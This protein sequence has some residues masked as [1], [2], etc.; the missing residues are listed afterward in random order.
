MGN[1][2]SFET[3]TGWKYF[4]NLMDCNDLHDGENYTPIICGEE[5]FGTGSNH[6]REKDGIWAALA[7]LQ[8]LASL[9]ID[10]NKPL[11]SVEDVVKRH[12]QKYGRYYYCRWD[13]EG[14]NE[15]NVNSMMDMMRVKTV[16]NKGLVC[17][18]YTIFLSDEFTY[19]DPVDGSVV[20]KQGIRFFT[21]DGSRIVFRLSGTAGS[22]ATLRMYIEQYERDNEKL[23]MTLSDALK[24]LVTVALDLCEIKKSC[25]TEIPTVVT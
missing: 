1:I 5:S 17:G 19:I 20:I 8:I 14:L 13:F 6:I 18:K 15:N 4:G 25:G 7:W 23:D 22:G 11:I 10:K 24:D 2:D 9:N 16:S 21:L 12:W 3:P